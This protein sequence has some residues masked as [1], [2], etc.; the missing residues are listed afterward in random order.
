[1]PHQAEDQR[2]AA[3]KQ[4]HALENF[5]QMGRRDVKDQTRDAHH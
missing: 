5:A 1:M 3:E 2:W 4:N